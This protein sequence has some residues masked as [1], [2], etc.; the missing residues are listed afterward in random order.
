M[1]APTGPWRSFLFTPADHARRVG[2]A[3]G[4]GADAVILDLED[5]V[6][7]ARWPGADG[8]AVPIAAHP[9]SGE[10]AVRLFSGPEPADRGAESAAVI[11]ADGTR[12]ASADPDRRIIGWWN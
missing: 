12:A 8:F 1:A 9:R 5:A 7:V 3:F 10:L 6:A 2:K 4:T 11:A